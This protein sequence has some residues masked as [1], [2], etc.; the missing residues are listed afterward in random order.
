MIVVSGFDG[1]SA[2]QIALNRIGITPEKYYASE[3]DK[4]AIKIAL[5]NYPDTVQLGDITQVDP[6]NLPQPDL[7]IGGYPCFDGTTLVL[8]TNGHTEIKDIKVGDL[9]LSHTGQWRS[10]T[11]IGQRNNVPTRIISGQCNPRTETTDN[12]PFYIRTMKRMWNPISKSQPRNFSPPVWKEAVQ[13]KSVDFCGLVSHP[14]A[15]S[16][17]FS[18]AFWY[19][20][21]RYTGD[22]WYRKSKRTDRKN[23][24][25]YQFVICCSFDEFDEL[26]T[27]FDSFG[28]RYGY[29]KERTGYR[30]KISRKELVQF[31]IPIGKGASNKSVHPLL[32][33]ETKENIIA[34]LDGLWDSDGYYCERE[35]NIK[36]TTTS[37]KLAY[38]VQQLVQSVY[39]VPAR[40]Y[41]DKRP[42]TT[43]IEGRLVSQKDTWQVV[44]KTDKREQDHSFGDGI[45]N[46]IPA[47]K[48]NDPSGRSIT[49]YNLEVET[50]HSYTANNLIVHNCQDESIAVVGHK[51]RMGLD[52]KRSGL[53]YQ[54]LRI[55]EVTNPRYF[56]LENVA[57]M[58]E[59]SRQIVSEKL[60]V[61]PIKINS[62]LV[63]GQGRNRLY[64][65]N[66]Q[67]V[68]QPPDRQI[69]LKDILESGAVDRDK[70]FCVDA[71]YW[72]GTTLEHYLNKH[73]RQ[74]VYDLPYEQKQKPLKLGFI[75]KNMQ[76]NRVY[77]I[78]AKSKTISSNGGGWG[79]KTGLY[80]MLEKGELIIRKLTPI[81]CERLQTIPDNYTEG[82]SSTQRY[83]MLGNSFTVDV[84]AHI[85]S[86]ANF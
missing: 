50:D 19:T 80:A 21:G 44:F 53:F 38:G 29:S 27:V 81:E 59:K 9:V 26:K 1:L 23:G 12:H 86:Y 33:G 7:L 63:S 66:I 49:V 4:Y 62:S 22:G 25:A 8:T 35:N 60:G 36:L 48:K 18:S 73:V 30:F 13:L 45:Y 10:V 56:L 65:T 55:L 47:C 16:S 42:T 74:I 67:G 32:F 17:G 70:S 15:E 79:A 3:I 57:S 11:G 77:D 31:V 2:G 84:I 68:Q 51:T 75:Q 83:K 64:W 6:E 46:W 39:G 61:E 24:L 34:Y 78:N 20:I 82:V 40:I 85:L 52:G 72:K 5:K 69:Y 71:N 43:T 54:W 37:K 58:S 14:L 28:Y 41:F 76:G